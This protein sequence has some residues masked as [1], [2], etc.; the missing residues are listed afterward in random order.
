MDVHENPGQWAEQHARQLLVRNGWHC[1]AERWRCR[2]GEIDLL[3]I[4]TAPSGF[5]LLAVVVK[6][7][8]IPMVL[9]GSFFVNT[10]GL[11]LWCGSRTAVGLGY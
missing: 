7:L 8:V 4:K 3:M 5:R 2:Y 9:I 1:C 6:V 10:L 11:V